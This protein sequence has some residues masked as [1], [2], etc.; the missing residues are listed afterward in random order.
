MDELLWYIAL[1]QAQ[2]IGP[3]TARTLIGYCGGAEAVFKAKS[4][5][6]LRIPGIGPAAT[7]ALQDPQLHRL[8]EREM[9]FMVKSGVLGLPF[10][11]TRYPQRLREIDDG[12]IVVYFKGSDPE[13]LS[14]PR[15]L[16]VV[17]TRQPTEYGKALCGEIVEGLKE[18]DV[19]IVSGLAFG[20]DAAS[21]RHSIAAGLPT[22]GIVAHGLAHLYPAEH[23]QLAARMC[24]HG[25][26]LSEHLHVVKAQREHFPMRN[27]LIAGICDALL[28]IESGEKGGSMITAQLASGYN[29]D[30]FALPGRARDPKSAGCNLL[31]RNSI[32]ALVGSATDVVQAMNWD[33]ASR[34]TG[35]QL[36]L[37]DDLDD[38]ERALLQYIVE[39]PEIHIDT[40]AV[41][42]G[43]DSGALA[44]VL[45]SL[46]FRGFV[47]P[48][49]GKRYVAI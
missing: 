47:R 7:T 13:L 20:I 26:L 30:V 21:H 4:K 22:V 23:R 43:M 32:A 2:G 1:A 27:R 45:L 18:A 40:L 35:V 25:G 31:I 19:V 44:A 46:E 16:S 38:T 14:A 39:R 10:N 28:V 17:G 36:S 3:V 12:P 15:I 8:A 24:E 6:L 41:A 42:A 37:F 33:T 5:E 9:D 29:R 34:V 49:P 48:L 11:D